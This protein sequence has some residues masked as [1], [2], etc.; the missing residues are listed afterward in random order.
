MGESS[1]TLGR[2]G[3]TTTAISMLSDWY[4]CYKS[5]LELASNANNYTKGGLVI[6]SHL[7]FDKMVFDRREY[8]RNDA[9]IRA[10]LAG[11]DTAAILQVNDGQHWVVAY[12]KRRAKKG[13]YIIIDP[14]DGKKKSL[15]SQ[16]KN[17]T[18]AAYFKRTGTASPKE[19][20]AIL[21]NSRLIKQKGAATV[22]VYN[23][24]QRFSIPD[25]ATASL[26]FGSSWPQEIMEISAALMKETE[27]GGQIPSMK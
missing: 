19:K 4:G 10:A 6:W 13:D 27:H 18:G 14:W 21:I 17:I 23:G 22:Y 2:W 11:K 12:S 9:N 16:Y 24:K 25:E 15:L 5:P 1:L 20:P 26:L 7:S 3:C 8:G